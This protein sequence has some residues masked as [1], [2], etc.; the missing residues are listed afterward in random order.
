M[1]HAT[2]TGDESGPARTRPALSLLAGYWPAILLYSVITLL[3]LMALNL[4]NAA[5]YIGADNDDGMRLIEVRDLMAGQG[6]FDLMQYRLGL[7]GGTL[8]HWSRLIDLPLANLISAFELFVPR[9]RAEALAATVWPLSLSVLLLAAMGLAGRRL[10]GPVAMHIALGFT[11]IF[12]ITGSRFLPGSLDHHNVQLVLIATIAAMLAD[13]RFSLG[14]YAAAGLAAGL[15]VAVGAE[16]MPQIATACLVVACLWLRHGAS[17]ARPVRAFCL[18]LMTTV[19]AA[20]FLTVPPSLY[21]AVTCDNLSLGFYSIVTV[22]AAS[23]LAATV[24]ASP[25][26]FSIRLLSLAIAAIPVAV[27]AVT[28]AP[29][30]L[31]NPLAG[32][33]PMLQRLWLANTTEARS[34]FAVARIDPAAWGAFYGAGLTAFAVALFSALQGRKPEQNAVLAALIGTSWLVAAIQVRS[35]T[36]SNLLAILPFA[37]LIADLRPLTHAGPRRRAASAFYLAMA[38][39]AMP[40]VWAMAG[41]AGVEGVSGF[42]ER[43]MPA[44]VTG[45]HRSCGSPQALAPLAGMTAATIAAPSDLGV[46]ILRYTPHRVLSAPYHRN[47]GGMLTELYIGL[48]N[49]AQAEAFLRGAQVGI[50]A[51]CRDEWQT[52]NLAKLEPQGL[53]AQLSAGV[54]P[55]YLEPVPGTEAADLRLFRVKP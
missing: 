31:G 29:Q 49:P 20:F 4:P 38:F 7:D 25:F 48:S 28:I 47:Q 34:I 36:F 21:T 51:F 54:V 30:C 9:E 44:P 5:D 55:A 10:G 19:T 32:L 46:P 43:L 8:M 33:D 50:L 45:N 16:T 42:R 27:T 52:R 26:R 40:S 1:T 37:M 3:L 14:S 39:A 23:L 35:S 18:A 24:L 22:G 11:A 6:W 17:L 12:L 41:L 53:Y 13:R 2:L 15:A